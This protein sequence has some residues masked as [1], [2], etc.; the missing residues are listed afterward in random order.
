MPERWKLRLIRHFWR[1]S[2]FEE[3]LKRLEKNTDIDAVTFDADKKRFYEMKKLDQDKIIAGRSISEILKRFDK[4]IKDPRSFTDGKKIVKIIKSFLKINCKLSE[5]DRKLL[6][7]AKKNN[8][9]K[10]YLKNLNLYLV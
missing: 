8:L 2:Y 10:I 6:D 5:L 7:F 1:P 4:K 9:K 3:L